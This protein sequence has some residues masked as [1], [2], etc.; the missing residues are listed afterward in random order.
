MSSLSRIPLL[1]KQEPI[2]ADLQ[3]CIYDK[4]DIYMTVFA[5]S[6]SFRSYN[7]KLDNGVP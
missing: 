3:R 5:E 7:L 1:N 4:Y 6:C 2:F